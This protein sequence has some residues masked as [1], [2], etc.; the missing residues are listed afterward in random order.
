MLPNTSST[1]ESMVAQI[2]IDMININHMFSYYKTCF[3]ASKTIQAQ[4]L[5]N[6]SIPKQLNDRSIIGF[7]DRTIGRHIPSSKKAEGALIRGSWQRC[8][9]VRATGHELFRGCV[10]FPTFD[11]NENVVAAIGYRLGRIRSG[12]NAIVEWHKPEP[13]AF[14]NKGMSFAREMI[15]EQTKH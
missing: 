2:D 12:D 9:L 1:F 14:V 6:S 5:S 4:L 3:L 13:D 11:I 7:S 8:G 15:N 10:V